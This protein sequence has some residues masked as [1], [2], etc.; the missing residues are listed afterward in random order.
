MKVKIIGPHSP[1]V[2]SQQPTPTAC[3]SG[4]LPGVRLKVPQF[5][6]VDLSTFDLKEVE[7]S[8]IISGPDNEAGRM[9]EIAM[10]FSFREA[11]LLADAL[12]KQLQRYRDIM[13]NQLARKPN[14]RQ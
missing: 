14:S 1:D 5:N 3:F 2:N 6:E 8:F 4:M 13:T 9:T 7:P 12:N 11:T 10:Q